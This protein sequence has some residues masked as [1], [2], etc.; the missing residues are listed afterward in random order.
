[1]R[2][3]SKRE[4]LFERFKIQKIAINYSSALKLSIK[5]KILQ[6]TN[7]IWNF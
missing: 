7:M 1:L 6:N 5:I 2:D 4:L 3:P